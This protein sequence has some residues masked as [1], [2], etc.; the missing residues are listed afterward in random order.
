MPQVYLYIS[1]ALMMSWP[2]LFLYFFQRFRG[3]R[4]NWGL[5]GVGAVTFVASQIGHFPFNWLVINELQ[6]IDVSNEGWGLVRLALFGGFSAGLF[7]ETARYLTYRFWAKDARSW[8]DGISMGLGH[9]GIESILLGVLLAVN[10]YVLFAIQDGRFQL[11]VGPDEMPLIEQQIAAMVNASPPILLL[12][13]VERFL[14][15]IFH[16]SLSL[17][18]LRVFTDGSLKWLAAA[19]GWH[20][21]G[22]AVIVYIA[23]TVEN[24]VV[25]ELAL[26]VIVLFA[27]YLI[28]RWRHIG[29]DKSLPIAVSE[30]P[31]TARPVIPIDVTSDR[32]DE[33]RYQ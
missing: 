19:I 5:F 2:F 7:E 12:G 23:G 29:E 15:I 1:A 6:L 8:R 10:T 32:L 21:F 25:A 18:V 14:T 28:R 11:L 24:P 30:P 17:M 22:N 27:A 3:G 26:A 16:L 20:A 4:F 13:A 9:G 31:P 33:S